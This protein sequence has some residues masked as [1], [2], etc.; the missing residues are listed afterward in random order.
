MRFNSHSCQ[1]SF[2]IILKASESYVHAFSR[3]LWQNELKNR[4]FAKRS[5][6]GSW[7]A[8]LW[9]SVRIKCG[10]VDRMVIELPYSSHGCDSLFLDERFHRTGHLFDA[11]RSS[12]KIGNFGAY[13]VCRL[14]FVKAAGRR[15]KKAS[16]L[17]R[18]GIRKESHCKESGPLCT[19]VLVARCTPLSLKYT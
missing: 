1:W 17:L 5:G 16:F 18:K 4:L 12:L 6:I 9:H 3:N 8:W 10:L 14:Y 7:V 15:Q 11:C 13:V 19:S 2:S